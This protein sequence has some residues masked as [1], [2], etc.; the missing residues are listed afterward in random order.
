MARHGGK[1]LCTVGM[2]VPIWRQLGKDTP[3]P[4]LAATLKLLFDRGPSLDK[5]SKWLTKV[6]G[7]KGWACSV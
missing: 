7:R 3:V 2:S 4:E 6:P 5:E 1:R